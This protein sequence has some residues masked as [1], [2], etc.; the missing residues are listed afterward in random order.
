M[1]GKDGNGQTVTNGKEDRILDK[2]VED[3]LRGQ[4]Y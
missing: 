2:I 1:K 4:E 3:T